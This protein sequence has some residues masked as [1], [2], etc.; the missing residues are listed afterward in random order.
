M[1]RRNRALNLIGTEL[2]GAQRLLDEPNAFLNLWAFLFGSILLLEQH[3]IASI[4]D[5]RLAP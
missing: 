2:S 3:E 4:A 1:D 5:T